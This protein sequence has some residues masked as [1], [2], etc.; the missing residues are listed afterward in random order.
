[1]KS[2][3][4]FIVLTVLVSSSSFSTRSL[5]VGE[6]RTLIQVENVCRLILG[7]ET[8]SFTAAL[9]GCF[10]TLTKLHYD[11]YFFYKGCDDIFCRDT[12]YR[13]VVGNTDRGMYQTNV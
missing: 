11:D 7:Q 9:R 2:N 13:D 12:R 4:L 10:L 5:T 8:Q 6:A 3:L 1:M